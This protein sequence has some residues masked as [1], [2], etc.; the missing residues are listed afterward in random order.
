MVAVTICT[1]LIIGATVIQPTTMAYCRKYGKSIVQRMAETIPRVGQKRACAT[2]AARQKAGS[3]VARS[4]RTVPMTGRSTQVVVMAPM[5]CSL[6]RSQNHASSQMGKAHI[7]PIVS[8][9][10]INTRASAAAMALKRGEAGNAIV[11]LP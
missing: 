2:S 1:L 9:T 8:G 4:D 10:Q 3:V 5:P 11:N 7:A 6:M